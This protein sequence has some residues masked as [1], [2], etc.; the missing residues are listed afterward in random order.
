MVVPTLAFGWIGVILFLLLAVFLKNL[1]QKNEFALIHVLLIFIF[2]CWLP[3]A[4]SLAFSINGWAAKI[5]TLFCVLALIMFIIAMSLQTGYIVYSNKHSKEN[6]DLWE[7]KNEWMMNLLSDPIEM[8]AGIFNWIGAIFIGTSL[9]QNNHHFF[10]AVVFI[11]SLQVIYCLA[12]LFRT[13]LNTPPKWIQSIKPN[14]VVLNLGFF[15]YYSVLL[16][17][18]MIHH[19]T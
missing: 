2:T 14:S 15:L 10:A 4:F 7:A 16:L 3:V 1:T 18:V 8:I 9:L 5:G 11:L 6:K 19:L 13:C 17:F 12:L